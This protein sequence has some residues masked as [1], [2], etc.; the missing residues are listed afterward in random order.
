MPAKKVANKKKPVARRAVAA[1]PVKKTVRHTVKK[2][3]VKPVLVAPRETHRPMVGPLS[4]I[5]RFGRGYFNLI[6]RSSRSE[7]WF[8]M[9][10]VFAV[11]WIFAALGMHGGVWETVATVVS[12]V[13]FIPTLTLS[14]RRFRDA[15]ISVWLYIIP[16][17]FVY[18]I[19]ILRGPTWAK[20]IMLDYLS[21]GMIAYSLFVVAYVIFV[22]VIACL[23]SKK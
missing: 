5:A 7:F 14:I 2:P 3:E 13:L 8:G 4:A 17:L 6:G 19:P 12:A 1:K 23:P 10:F 11:N 22:F 21:S 20:L 18:F 15:G 9:L 16:M